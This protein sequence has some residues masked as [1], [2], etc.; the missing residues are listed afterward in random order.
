MI[1]III[2]ITSL[3]LVKE[4]GYDKSLLK[5]NLII[6]FL[7]YI[8]MIFNLTLFDEI[9]GRQGLTAIS[10]N[11]EMLN[12][13]FNNSFNIIPFRTIKLFIRGYNNRIVSNRAFYENIFGNI[14]AFVPFAFFI[15]L[16]F[17]KI[18]NYYKFL[19]IMIIIVIQIEFLQFITMSGACDIDDVILNL[20]GS[21]IAYL[22]FSIKDINRLMK[23]IFLLEKEES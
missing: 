10:W 15:P 9:Y 18:N 17:K 2:Y 14:L 11:R 16:I 20:V 5:I 12:K 23:K 21:S 19:I 6:Y 3:R 1:C 8:I 4:Y 7:V 13:Y 22:M